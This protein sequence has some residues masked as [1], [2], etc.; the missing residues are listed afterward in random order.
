M[1]GITS[2]MQDLHRDLAAVRMHSVCYLAVLFR[3]SSSG[4]FSRERLYTTHS[5]RRVTA[6]NDQTNITPGTLGKVGRE[7]V[8]FV[9]VLEP[10]VH[11]AHEHPV[12]ERRE[13]EVERG[14]QVWV[15]SVG[16]GR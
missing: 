3:F 8:V 13:T 16:H 6:S 15:L 14:E 9:A 5:V 7:A 1:V 2:G 10:G 12:L 11:G 4:E